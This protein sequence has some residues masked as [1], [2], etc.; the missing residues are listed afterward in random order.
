MQRA[1]VS[2]AGTEI[3]LVAA[4]TPE[5]IPEFRRLCEEYQKSLPFSL[6]FQGFDAEMRGLPGKYARPGGAMYVAIA[7]GRAI[8]CIAMRPL[9]AGG[10]GGCDGCG[11]GG[12]RGVCEVEV[13]VCEMKRLYVAPEGRGRGVGKMLAERLIADARAAGYQR[14]KLDTSSDMLSA[15]RLYRSLGFVETERYNDDPMEDTLYFVL[16]LG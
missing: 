8:G 15:Q 14:M 11:G 4:N 6:C 5:L 2:E 1:G 3:R 16:E 9:D 10:S 13:G 12:E 7:G